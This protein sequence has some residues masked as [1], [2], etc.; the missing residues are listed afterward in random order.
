VG[1]EM[2]IRDSVYA[3]HKDF[4]DS[5]AKSVP[6]D[7]LVQASVLLVSGCLDNE[8]S[9]D[10][11]RSGAFTGALQKV[12]NG[13]SFKGSHG[14]FRNQIRALLKGQQTPDY[15]FTG[16]RNKTFESQT[17]FTI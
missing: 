14:A 5:I 16:A 17:P 8:Y 15:R 6:Q 12:W 2:C 3:A 4:Y 7:A 1:S 11:P 13:G 10:G 9:Y